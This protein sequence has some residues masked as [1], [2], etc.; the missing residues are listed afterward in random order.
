MSD[1]WNWYIIIIV[2]INIV[3]TFLL[4][5][6]T[7]KIKVSD[8]KDNK[9]NHTFDGIVECDNP[10]PRWWFILFVLC[11]IFSIGYLLCYPGLGKFPGLLKWSSSKQL[12]TEI[13]EAKKVYEPLFAKFS[14]ESVEDLSRN[15][16]A[17]K[18]A[19]SL[20]VNNCAPCHGQDATGGI[21]F[22]NLTLNFWRWG[23][24]PENIKKTI[25][26]GRIGIMPPLK[27]V[28]KNDRG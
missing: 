8:L 27:A 22:P 24:T 13:S 5:Y 21:G 9:L 14:S 16:V 23:G 7:R 6:L 25:T 26:N 2:L 17:L 3:G 11:I 15:P 10:L 4:L 19:H 1:F 28:L 12:E 20:F 18:M